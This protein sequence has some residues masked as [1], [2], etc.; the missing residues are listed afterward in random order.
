MGFAWLNPSYELW[1][2]RRDLV[3]TYG[4]TFAFKLR[5]TDVASIYETEPRER[6]L[7]EFTP[8]DAEL[9]A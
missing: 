9:F 4:Q 1:G 3:P 2:L 7:R 6:H 8:A 5:A